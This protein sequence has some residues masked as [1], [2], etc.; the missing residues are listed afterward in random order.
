VSAESWVSVDLWIWIAFL[1]GVAGLLAFD[2]LAFGR[3]AVPVR[4]AAVWSVAWTALGLG[5]AGVLAAWR[6]GGPAGEYLTG[7][8]LEKSLSLDNLFVFALIFTAL[9]VPVGER[10]RILLLG[11]GGAIVLRGL[12]ILGGAALLDAF[13]WSVYVLGALLVVT[14]IRMAR[15]RHDAADLEQSRIRR[16]I[17]RVLPPGAAALALVMVFDV[18]FALD[19]IPAIFAITRDTFVV[20]AANAF[21]L[22]GLSALYFLLAD[23]AERFRHLNVGLAAVLVFVGAKMAL[24]DVVHVPVWLSLAVIVVSLGTAIA[25]SRPPEARSGGP[26]PRSTPPG[27]RP[28]PDPGSPARPPR[29]AHPNET[30]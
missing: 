29:S 5:F 3:G 12:F 11:I 7:F 10:R 18:V 15:H 24:V 6:G 30:G 17:G 27:A 8:L 22:L 9:G 19:S 28:E 20:F 21:S 26:R 23:A 25:L 2:L 13:H 4:R 1:A 14:G 16:A